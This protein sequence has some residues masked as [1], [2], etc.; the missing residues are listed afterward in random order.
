M[1]NVDI[2]ILCITYNHVEYICQAMDGFLMQEGDFSYE[3]IVYDDAS[4]DRTAEILK[5]YKEKFP[6][7][8][9]LCLA[10]E[11]QYSQGGRKMLY[12]FAYPYARG[13]YFSLCDG[14][15]SWIYEHKLYEQFRYMETHPN[16]SMCIHN[17]LRIDADSGEKI[18]QI[19]GISSRNMTKE[20]IFMDS[21]GLVPT[22][23]FFFRRECMDTIPSSYFKCPVGDTPLRF[24]CA[25]M[26]EIYYIDE[27][28][29]VRNY[30]HKGSWNSSIK[31]TRND[32][33]F[34]MDYNKY[35]NIYDKETDGIYHRWIKKIQKYFLIRELHDFTFQKL[36][37]D[38]FDN[39]FEMARNVYKIDDMIVRNVRQEIFPSNKFF[40]DEFVQ[41]SILAN[42]KGC[43][44]YGAGYV[45]KQVSQYL[46]LLYPEIIIKGFIVTGAE[47]DAIVEGVE[48]Y[49]IDDIVENRNDIPV[50]ITVM[51]DIQSEI[52]EILKQKQILD[53]FCLSDKMIRVVE[54]VIKNERNKSTKHYCNICKSNVSGF[55][56]SGIDED[57]F[58]KHRIIGGG[59]RTNS[60]CPVCGSIDRERFL[61]YVVN[62]FTNI[63]YGK[64][65]VLHFA[66]EN[67]VIKMVQDNIYCDYYSADY[68]YGRAV[69]QIDA[70]DIPFKDN[71]FDYVIMNHVL[72]HIKSEKRALAEL[73]RVLKSTGK[74]YL[75]FPICTD[76]KTIEETD[77]LLPEQRLVQFGQID[78]VRLYGTDYKERI[79]K[80]GFKV[81]IL[82][83]YELLSNERISQWGLI[84]DDVI[85][86]CF[87]I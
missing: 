43:F 34:C 62:R 85:L 33:K 54:G 71:M 53:F 14:D 46:K 58:K 35:L 82:R 81:N 31:D 16:T 20:E 30:M 36:S 4:T 55:N 2:S 77:D 40:A 39:V 21:F 37:K 29:G 18:P 19:R 76:Q 48:V 56:P 45:G 74:L 5:G 9:R 51:P 84:K 23:S 69:H 75:S 27:I 80:A 64:V 61:Y 17:A 50:L 60:K 78:H 67:C 3:I 12:H 32:Q 44:L 7:K 41:F 65:K 70:T 28:W 25:N 22:S 15:D 42:K 68:E 72:E 87:V 47:H 24:H 11:N 83:P 63:S 57:I 66:P 79:E 49:S 8:I 86:E 13:R 26:G 73:K 10:K 52:S 38:V 59:Y 1:N 6:D